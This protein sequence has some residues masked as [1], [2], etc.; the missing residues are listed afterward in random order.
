MY[1]IF[2]YLRRRGFTLAEILVATVIAGYCILPVVGT[3]QGG[4]RHTE[5]FNHREKLRMLARSRL[6]KEISAG[7]FN[8]KAVNFNTDYHYVYQLDD[9]PNYYSFNSPLDPVNPSL[10][11]PD[12]SATDSII[13]AY[14]TS[15]EIREDVGVSTTTAGLLINSNLL[16]PR[17]LKALVVK[18]ELLDG[19]YVLATDSIS[20]FSLLSIPSFSERYIWVANSSLLQITAIDPTTRSVI[21]THDLPLID[22]GLGKTNAVQNPNRPWNI[23]VHPTQ[24]IIGIQCAST[25]RLLNIDKLHSDYRAN[26][27]VE[28]HPAAGQFAL[29][30]SSNPINAESDRGIVFRPDGKYF[31][32]TS[33]SNMFLYV[34]KIDVASGT[35]IWPPPTALVTGVALTEADLNSD[36]FSDMVAGNDGYLYL[37]VKTKNT[38]IRFPMYPSSFTAGWTYEKIIDPTQTVTNVN[39]VLTSGDGKHLYFGTTLNRVAQFHSNPLSRTGMAL[40]SL[41][42]TAVVDTIISPDSK[43][44]MMTD[45]FPATNKGGLW[46]ATISSILFQN[47]PLTITPYQAYPKNIDADQAITSPVGNIAMF[48]NDA[49]SEMYFVDIANHA[50]GMYQSS[51][52][53]DHFL[54]YDTTSSKPPSDMVGR[55]GNYL[56]V[57]TGNDNTDSTIEYFDLDAFKIDR[58]KSITDLRQRPS[59]IAINPQGTRFKVGYGNGTVNATAGLDTFDLLN[60]SLTTPPNV[61]MTGHSARAV[62]SSDDDTLSEYSGTPNMDSFF[63]SLETVTKNGYY[64]PNAPK[65]GSM[66]DATA[67]STFRDIDLSADWVPKD[68]VS[69]A[70]GGFLLLFQGNDGISRLDWIGKI[71]WGTDKGKYKRF[72]RWVS[73]TTPSTVT[74]ADDFPPRYAQNLALSPD[75]K[76]LAIECATTTNKVYLY[77]FATNNFGHETQLNGL[78]ADYRDWNGSYW[79]FGNVK[80]NCLFTSANP[81]TTNIKLKDS[82]TCNESWT[83]FKNYPGNFCSAAGDSVSAGTNVGKRDSNRR[84]FGYFQPDYEVAK[85]AGGNQD[86]TRVFIDYQFAGSRTTTGSTANFAITGNQTANT[87]SLIQIDF[88]TQLGD[89]EQGVFTHTSVVGPGVPASDGGANENEHL[90]MGGGWQRIAS[91]STRPFNFTPT[92]LRT[93]DVIGCNANVA[94]AITFSR[95]LANPILFVMDA[96]NDDF[97]VLKPGRNMT[98]IDVDDTFTNTA[99]KQ[100]VVSADGQK[101]IFAEESGNKR[102]FISN[103]SN[104]D[105]FDFAG[106]TV[107]QSS[108][109][110]A[111]FGSLITAFPMTRSPRALA[112]KPFNT[113]KSTTHLGKYEQLATFT[114]AIMGNNNAALASGGIYIMGGASTTAAVPAKNIFIFNPAEPPPVGVSIAPL[115]SPASLTLAVKNNSVVAYDNMLYSLNGASGTAL[116]SASDWVQ[117]FNPADSSVRSSADELPVNV[118]PSGSPLSTAG[119][120]YYTY[121]D[122]TILTGSDEKSGDKLYEIFDGSGVW[123]TNSVNYV[124]SPAWIAID[125]GA[126]NERTVDTIR[127]RNGDHPVKRFKFQGSNIA[128]PSTASDSADW[129]T[130]YEAPS[131]ISLADYTWKGPYTLSPTGSYRHYR[132]VITSGWE[133]EIELTHLEMID[134][135]GAAAATAVPLMTKT[136]NDSRANIKLSSTAACM[137]PYGIVSA[138]GQDIS[139]TA[140]RTALVYWPHAYDKHTPT[141]T[142]LPTVR[143]KFDETSGTIATDFAG[144]YNGTVTNPTWVS[145]KIKNGLKLNG[146]SSYVQATRPVQDDFTIACWIKTT[147]VGNGLPHYETRSIVH[148]E[149]GGVNDDFGFGIDSNGMLTYGDGKYGVGDS[150]VRTTTPINTGV[151]RHVA[152]TR[153]KLTGSV[154]LY[155]DGN[156]EISGTC[157]TGNSLGA[158]ANITI[159]YAN[160]AGALRY[161]EGILDDVRLYSVALTPDQIKG[162]VQGEPS[163]SGISREITP[164][165][166]AVFGHSLVWHKGK[167]YRIGGYTAGTATATNIN[168]FDFDTNSW[169]SV[170]HNVASFTNIAGNIV[171]FGQPAY[172]AVC[173]FGDEIFVF[174]GLANGGTFLNTAYAW[175][176]ETSVVRQLGNMPAA[177]AYFSAVPCGSSIYLLG[178]GSAATPTA[179]SP[180][181]KFTP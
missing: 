50:A 119:P 116:T 113:I 162:I 167:I 101:L 103:I 92:W 69:M 109:A 53:G 71:K 72:A 138:G 10:T 125:L 1:Q 41:D 164:M 89:M 142:P 120:L 94:N 151:W 107:V 85:F 174:G 11:L 97:W 110:P 145:G 88:N 157:N 100:L 111:S 15:V 96:G 177:R 144:L 102:L 25:I 124:T 112:T 47:S 52:P 44:L 68:L 118:E 84:F 9:N 170:S 128:A 83:G 40:F 79:V 3:M 4:I 91:E 56:I 21:E 141:P 48:T 126:G 169:T 132:M 7:A 82:L 28:S 63:A 173:S 81:G 32:V 8:H 159:G 14:Q 131:D 29:V 55:Q 16:D 130:L 76:Y 65:P 154:S 62:Y 73:S 104:P 6:N 147:S 139:G 67:S 20:Y 66:T 78:V 117:R 166:T 137:T 150:H 149:V 87:T 134:S 64:I 122:G 158:A 146:T 39:A 99:N 77:D 46:I 80:S 43:Y 49:D 34:Y 155:I 178:G 2:I 13:Y 57:G 75:E 35:M 61:G 129:N 45:P 19:P 156:L 108:I 180:V 106:G 31:F 93:Y 98:R 179:N 17:G 161:L 121:T 152:V 36:D 58:D 37:S 114:F 148:A 165:N 153:V 140:T 171:T 160:D 27:V 33:H 163:S 26:A 51:M 135:L 123:E 172:A 70:N 105:D 127:F 30:S 5:N 22:S 181:H 136:M 176:P 143:Y 168:I 74:P 60:N 12:G 86:H 115:A 133:S 175:N 90:V 54:V 59:T 95:D 18:S 42:G 24:K 38:V 23:D